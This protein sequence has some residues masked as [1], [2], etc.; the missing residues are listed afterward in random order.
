MLWGCDIGCPEIENITDEEEI[1]PMEILVTDVTD[2][3]TEYDLLDY[4]GMGISF[5]SNEYKDNQS[6][7]PPALTLEEVCNS[8]N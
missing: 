7:V 3:Y 5:D 6:A 1:V 2:D 8:E 4:I